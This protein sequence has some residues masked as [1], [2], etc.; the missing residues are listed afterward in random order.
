VIRAALLAA[1]LLFA[2]TK[3]ITVRICCRTIMPSADLVATVHTI[4]DPAN[5]MLSVALEGPQEHHED[6]PLHGDR[7]P[8]TFQL[9]RFQHLGA[10]LY[11]VTVTLYRH[12]EHAGRIETWKAGEARDSVRIGPEPDG[13]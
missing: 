1:L 8:A 12:G 3:P 7:E 4:T 11:V 6:I 5:V 10:G 13:P 9:P 2:D